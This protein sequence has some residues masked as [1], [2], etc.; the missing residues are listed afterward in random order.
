MVSLE[1]LVSDKH[2]YQ[3]FKSFFDFKA[4]K[5]DLLSV[6]ELSKL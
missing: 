1:Q 4:V 3:K 6:A 2:Q 5:S